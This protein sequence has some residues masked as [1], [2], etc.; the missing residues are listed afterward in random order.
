MH[1]ETLGEEATAD[2]GLG[3]LYGSAAR[4]VESVDDGVDDR[5]VEDPPLKD[6]LP[7]RRR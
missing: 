6:L 3:E 2:D 5:G 1:H 7:L 4:L